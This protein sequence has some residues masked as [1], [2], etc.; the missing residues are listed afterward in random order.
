M[1]KNTKRVGLK[2]LIGTAAPDLSVPSEKKVAPAPAGKA[3]TIGALD[4]K[5]TTKRVGNLV[6][7]SPEDCVMWAY[8]DRNNEGLSH[9]SL[10][11]LGESI[12][13]HKQFTPAIARRVT[14]EQRESMGLA[15]NVQ[16]EI[17]AG[18]RRYE[19]TKLV[20]CH[21]LLSIHDIDDTTAFA[22]MVSENDDREDIQPFSRALSFKVALDAGIYKNQAELVR[23]QQA[24]N[25]SKR[26]TKGAISK[27]LTAAD[28]SSREWLWP[29]LSS[30]GIQ[31]IPL[32]GAYY[33]ELSL[34]KDNGF[35]KHAKEVVASSSASTPL[36]LINEIVETWG[37]GEEKLKADNNFAVGDLD[38]KVALSKKKSVFEVTGGTLKKSDIESLVEALHDYL[39]ANLT[40]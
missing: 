7:V 39:E 33:L 28:L 15:A 24:E 34:V 12:Q 22:I 3:S 8:A 30:L 13:K 37:K 27:M 25:S 6:E 23:L 40:E 10:L 26:Y 5:S 19:A 32:T 2:D 38:V 9:E 35:V 36:N 14:D 17:I 16:F 29:K 18:R 11:D 20:G 1:A 31:D 4:R 21:L